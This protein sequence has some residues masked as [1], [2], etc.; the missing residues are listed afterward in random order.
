MFIIEPTRYESASKE[1]RGVYKMI[2]KELGFIPPHLEL[3][4]T[5]DK[6]A[7]IEFIAYQRS[8][9]NHPAIDAA[10]LPFLRLYIAHKEQRTYCQAFNTKLL[11]SQ[12]IDEQ[13]IVDTINTIE[14]IP[15]AD[16]Q[17]ALAQEVI[18]ALYD[19]SNFT[20][21]NI[22]RLEVW[23]FC[24]KDFFDLLNYCC[25]FMSKSKMIEIY[26]AKKTDKEFY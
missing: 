20:A 11:R 4:A 14:E 9:M 3:F 21:E 5:I 7:L 22:T 2:H 1:L 12:H 18:R 26:L 25:N 6:E 8:M 23:G 17:R 16:N 15:V 13:C 10:M 19:T 24:H